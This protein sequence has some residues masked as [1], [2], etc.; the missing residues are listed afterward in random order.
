MSSTQ[1]TGTQPGGA[2]RV[3]ENG[4]NIVSD[5][6]RKG[7][8]RDLF[9]PWAAANVSVFGISYGAFTLDFGIS[10][11]Q[12][13][14]AGVIGIIFSFWLCGV[15]A[16]SGKH[17]SAPTM[18]LSRAAFG[19]EG[20]KLPSAISWILTVGWE[21]VLTILATLATATV[22]E[23]LGWGGGTT[24]KLIAMVVVSVI[25]IGAGVL[26]FD[27]IMKV[28]TWIT[29]VTGIL[30]VGYF[31]LVWDKVDWNAINSIPTGSAQSFI[32]ALIFLLT[33]FGLG[34]VIAAGDYSRYLPRNSSNSGIVWW[35]TLG[36]SIFPLILLIFGLMLAGSSK[37]LKDGIAMDPIGALAAELPTWYLVPFVIV[38]VLG[39]VGGAVLDIYSSGLALLSAGIRIP[40]PVAALIDGILMVLGTTYV[41]FFADNFLNPFM[42][43][44]ITLGVPVAVWAGIMVVDVLLRRRDYSGE[45]LFDAR[46]RYGAVNPKTMAL[47]AVGTIVGWGLVTNGYAGWLK[48]QG[49]L[50]GPLGLGGRE[51]P[52]AWANLGVL[53]AL[54][55]GSLGYWAL[56]ANDVRR[57]EARD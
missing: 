18:I 37:D 42:G 23:R 36:A 20:Q 48:W 26:G 28:Q 52:W 30:T 4:I 13:F 32:G 39:L 27:T 46:G 55:I 19:V 41:V 54:L 17:G 40:R 38:A 7:T 9:W 56:C 35:T 25:I 50:L 1:S 33:G 8:P 31:L 10:F 21:T 22:F 14:V 12:A 6:E 43:F 11:W 5:A 2:F 3:E 47:M 15:I 16:I 45:D 29:Y 34:W 57:Q 51:G 24:T 44:L 53:A 49:Y